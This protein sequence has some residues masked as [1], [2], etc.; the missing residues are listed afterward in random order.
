MTKLIKKWIATVVFVFSMTQ[1]SAT[2]VLV[3]DKKPLSIRLEVNQ[4]RLIEFPDNISIEIPNKLRSRL[5]VSAAAG[6]MYITPIAEFPKTRIDIRLASTNELIFVDL[7]AVE[8][9]GELSQGSVKVVTMK[10]VKKKQKEDTD[11]IAQSTSLTIKDLI[12]HASHDFYAPSRLKDNSKPIVETRIKSKLNLD[13]LFM[14]RSAAL[15]DLQPMKQYRTS[16]YTLTAI[17]VTNRTAKRQ[18]V[19]FADMYPSFIAASSQHANVGPAG[20]LAQSTVLYLVTERPLSEDSVYA[21]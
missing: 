4:E 21:F 7:F 13:L 16:R 3:W 14:G 11:L 12:Q 10:E 6:V 17:L 18:P 1:A 8:P 2:E 9:T 20:G 19:I 15:F 5:R